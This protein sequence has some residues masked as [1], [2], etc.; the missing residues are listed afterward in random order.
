MLATYVRV[1]ARELKMARC[2]MMSPPLHLSDIRCTCFP[3]RS[4]HG[5]Q[6][7]VMNERPNESVYVGC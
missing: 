7:A 6:K 5:K 3:S 1:I 4:C 2:H